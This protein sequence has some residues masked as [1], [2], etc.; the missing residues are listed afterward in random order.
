MRT[1]DL[2]RSSS[3]MISAGIL[4]ADVMRLSDELAA[5]EGTGVRLI[6]VDVMD[7]RYVPVMTVGP[8]FVKGI[9]TSFLKGVMRS[10]ASILPL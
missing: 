7:G 8:A 9:R 4:S 10:E 2:I 6:H 1:I 5:L 3:P